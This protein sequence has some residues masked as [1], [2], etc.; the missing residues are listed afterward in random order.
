MK[1]TNK[2]I[3][4]NHFKNRLKEKN[5]QRKTLLNR[6]RDNSITENK[7]H[8]WFLRWEMKR[9]R[10]GEKRIK[11]KHKTKSFQLVEN[12]T[13]KHL[14]S[15]FLF[16]IVVANK[17]RMTLSNQFGFFSLIDKIVKVEKSSARLKIVV[18]KKCM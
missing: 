11:H 5:K 10:E 8:A 9:N 14:I 7:S 6:F 15:L 18:K 12:A 4:N 17:P 2:K 3:T 1:K 16:C 13:F